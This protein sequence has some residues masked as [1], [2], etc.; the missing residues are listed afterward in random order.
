MEEAIAR[1]HEEGHSLIMV[2]IN[3]QLKGA[4]EIQPQVRPEVKQIISRLRQL[5]IA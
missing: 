4:I 5:H 3:E 2:A 1:S